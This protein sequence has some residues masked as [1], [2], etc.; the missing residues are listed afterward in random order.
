MNSR[1]QPAPTFPEAPEITIIYADSAEAAPFRADAR[2]IYL[3]IMPI[4]TDAPDRRTGELDAERAIL[5][6]AFPTGP[7]PVIGHTAEGAPYL[8][9]ADASLSVS[10]DR[11]RAVMAL[12]PKGTGTGV[13]IESTDRTAQLEKVADKFLTDREKLFCLPRTG[14]AFSL[15]HP[16]STGERFCYLTQA[17]V[18]KEAVYKLACRPGWPLRDIPLPYPMPIPGSATASPWAPAGDSFLTSYL[19]LSEPDAMICVAVSAEN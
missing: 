15:L 14:A 5:A 18:T 16:V 4:S 10:H 8:D 11:C 19:R 1:F 9:G 13:D 12:A 7:V 6:K 3:Y 2:G 17:W